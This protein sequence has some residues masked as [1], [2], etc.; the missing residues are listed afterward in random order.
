MAPPFPCGLGLCCCWGK[1]EPGCLASAPSEPRPLHPGSP[2]PRQPHPPPLTPA[3]PPRDNSGI[4]R[5]G[6]LSFTS[7]EF[8]RDS[9][10][11][12]CGRH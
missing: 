10:A 7:T 1:V 12:P 4:D 6:R 8:R 3:H 11:G 9:A 2:V 5:E